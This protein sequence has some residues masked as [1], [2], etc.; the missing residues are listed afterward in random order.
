MRID[1]AGFA[2]EGV[3]GDHQAL[4]RLV[5]RADRLGFD[6][7]WF[8][9]FHFKRDELPY[10][11]TLLLGAEILG[12]TERIRFGTSILVLPLRHPLL[13]AE[14]IAQLDF[15]SNGRIDVGIGRGTE[16]STFSTLGIDPEE[17]RQRFTESFEIL[18][19]AWT[20]PKSSASGEVWQFSDV[21][22]GP[23]PIQKPHPPVYVAG[24]SEETIGLAA[25]R[26]L[27]LLLSLEPNEARQLP[28]FHAQLAK[29]GGSLVPLET[30]SLSRY[31]VVAPTAEAANARV[32]VLLTLLNQKRAHMFA[33]RGQQAPA[34]RSREAML[35]DFTIA[36]TP[37][38][39]CTQLLDL[40]SR[41][42][43]NAIRC[44]FSANGLFTNE[45]ALVGMELFALEVMPTVR[46]V[47]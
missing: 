19:N 35:A 16:P 23:S 47:V 25:K 13:I 9:E 27:P 45:E 42:G 2:R 46:H 32:D 5:E 14:Q 7:I 12:R 28:V 8:N 36:G 20:E 11:D 10:P 18:F 38:E 24:V 39:C 29:Y 41:T 44:L 43:V 26:G 33:A 1:L 3:L 6:G 34:P 37:Q 31:V 30:S 40:R 22:V 4:M 15:Q 21:A 17:A